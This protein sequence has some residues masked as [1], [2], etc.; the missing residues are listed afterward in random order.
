MIVSTKQLRSAGSGP[1]QHFLCNRRIN[2]LDRFQALARRLRLRAKLYNQSKEC[3]ES[4]QEGILPSPF[5]KLSENDLDYDR[6]AKE[7][8]GELLTK[9][10]F[11]SI[12]DCIQVANILA[13]IKKPLH[14]IRYANKSTAASEDDA[15]AL[16]IHGDTQPTISKANQPPLTLGQRYEG[17]EQN[18]TIRLIVKA[19]RILF[20]HMLDAYRQKVLTKAQRYY[21]FCILS[22]D[23]SLTSSETWS[24]LIEELKKDVGITSSY[25]AFERANLI[26]IYDQVCKWISKRLARE[27][28]SQTNN[29]KQLP[30]PRSTDVTTEMYK[31]SLHDP[32]CAEFLD[33]IL[34]QLVPELHQLKSDKILKLLYLQCSRGIYRKE[35]FEMSSRELV[36][37]D[38][39]LH[40]GLKAYRTAISIYHRATTANLWKELE[41]LGDT[42]QLKLIELIEGN[43]IDSLTLIQPREK[44]V[45]TRRGIAALQLRTTSELVRSLSLDLI[46]FLALFTRVAYQIL[47]MN[48]PDFRDLVTALTMQNSS[49]DLA[50]SILQHCISLEDGVF[51]SLTAPKWDCGMYQVIGLLRMLVSNMRFNMALLKSLPENDECRTIHQRCESHLYCYCRIAELSLGIIAQSVQSPSVALD[52]DELQQTVSLIQNSLEEAQQLLKV[53]F[54]RCYL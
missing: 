26:L 41:L 31:R 17:M 6:V 33:T 10:T 48:D 9:I 47:G 34:L 21:L 46:G 30:A 52:P 8:V 28:E 16:P 19:Q 29:T 12:R 5:T 13:R 37:R 39:T 2:L 43:Q 51:E 24:N 3:V 15:I 20:A 49:D 14:R 11:L 7:L 45:G 35:F 40:N 27:D 22:K 23:C 4:P 18:S 38:M 54:D 36:K 42:T 53:Q 1:L 25:M 44:E 50:P 32:F